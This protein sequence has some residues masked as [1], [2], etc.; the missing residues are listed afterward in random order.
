MNNIPTVGELCEPEAQHI[1]QLQSWF[2]TIQALRDWSV[3]TNTFEL[4]PVEFS[5]L[6]QFK[7]IDSFSFVDKS[8]ALL[9]FG[10]FYSWQN[11]THF[12]RLAIAPA[13]RGRGLIQRLI[14]LLQQKASQIKKNNS[15]SLFVQ[16]ENSVALRNYLKCGFTLHPCPDELVGK[17]PNHYFMVADSLHFK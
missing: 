9:G 13:F 1:L 17:I 6:I 4:T 2:P 16:K 5:Y 11:R 15:Y 14:Q 7:Q 3:A 10:Q 8:G 12:P